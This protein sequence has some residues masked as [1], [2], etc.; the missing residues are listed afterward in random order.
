MMHSSS[1]AAVEAVDLVKT[2]PSGRRSEPVR[3]IDMLN[4][5]VE[6]GC[7]FG[8][9]GPNGAGKST[10]IKI[11]STLAHP[12]SGTAMVAGADVVN[13]PE[14]VR[15]DIGFVA[16][17]SV[18]DPAATGR[19]NLMLAARLHGMR[20]REARARAGELLERFALSGAAHRPVNTYSGGMAR[21]LDIAMGLIHRPAVL[22]LDEPTTGLD[23]QART[24]L[25]AEIM[26]ARDHLTV[27]LT[28][29][30]LEEA[31]RLADR[32]AIVDRGH[33]VIHGTPD[34]LKSSLHGDGVVVELGHNAAVD[35]AISA[36]GQIPGLAGISADGNSLRARTHH[37]SATIPRVLSVLDNADI[38]VVSATVYRPSLDDVYLQHT[39]RAFQEVAA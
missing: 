25:W 2:Y 14:E 5:S 34:E 18:S 37:A 33:V 12:D 13:N 38:D 27:I 4:F 21:K 39:G 17:E 35:T 20:K 24:E 1:D 11:L 30:Y 26:S 16:Q 22:F 28:T 9:L 8:L 31:D 32:L 15:R 23:P 3:A 19:E 29:H 6:A 36:V 10:T 7:V